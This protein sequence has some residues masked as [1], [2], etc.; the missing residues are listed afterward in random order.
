MALLKIRGFR[1]EA[2]VAPNLGCGAG[3]SAMEKTLK[4]HFSFCRKREEI[5]H[6]VET[7]VPDDHARFLQ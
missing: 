5:D 6:C 1:G 3:F 7:G 4:L 2:S